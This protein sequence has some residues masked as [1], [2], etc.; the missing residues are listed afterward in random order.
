MDSKCCPICATEMRPFGEGR[1]AGWACPKCGNIIAKTLPRGYLIIC[2]AIVLIVV[3]GLFLIVA[4][5]TGALVFWIVIWAVLIAVLALIFAVPAYVAYHKMRNL[6]REMRR[7]QA[8]VLRK[9]TRDWEVDMPPALGISAADA[10]IRQAAYQRKGDPGVTLSEWTND[11]VTFQVGDQELELNV[12]EDIYI[13]AEA[14]NEGLLVF[15]GDQFKY[16]I[17][18]V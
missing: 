6:T 7:E 12:P 16:F 9:R 1:E 4:P 18:G 3:P 13:G 5:G 10:V 15:Q 2:W 17:K 14:G 8:T 11:F